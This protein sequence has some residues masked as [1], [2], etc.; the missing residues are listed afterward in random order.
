VRTPSFMRYE[1][2]ARQLTGTN[3]E[4]AHDRVGCEDCG[5]LAYVANR[6]WCLLASEDGDS[7]LRTDNPV[8]MTGFLGQP[9]TALYYPLSPR[10]C[11]VACSMP[12]SWDPTLAPAGANEQCAAYTLLKGG[13]SL[14]DFYLAKAADESAIV[15]PRFDTTVLRTMLTQVLGV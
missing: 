14:I 6:D 10:I 12:S 4:P 8:F 15:N 9:G 7:F 5:D 13:A 3:G 1:A 11:F 2:A